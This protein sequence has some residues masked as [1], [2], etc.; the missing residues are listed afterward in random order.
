MILM[1]FQSLR[2]G[3]ESLLTAI[4]RNMNEMENQVSVVN[5]FLA[6]TLNYEIIL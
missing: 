1:F 6:A 2:I 5:L 4:A 3:W